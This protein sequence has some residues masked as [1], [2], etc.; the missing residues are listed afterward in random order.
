MKNWNTK[1]PENQLEFLKE[2]PVTEREECA[3]FCRLGNAAKAYR[4]SVKKNL[5]YKAFL[6]RLKEIPSYLKRNINK[7]EFGFY[8]H[9]NGIQQLNIEQNNFSMKA[10]MKNHLSVKDYAFYCKLTLQRDEQDLCDD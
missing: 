2:L 4:K 5:N 1:P 8:Q 9:S 3:Q 10:Y 7:K 6:L